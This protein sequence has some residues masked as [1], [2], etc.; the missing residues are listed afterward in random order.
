MPTDLRS[1][2]GYDGY[3][4]SAEGSMVGPAGPMRPMLAEKGH[5][6]VLTSRPGVPRKLFVHRA[7]LLAFVGPPPPGKPWAL[8]RDDI[9][10]N[11]SL[12]NLYWGSRQDN[13]DD[14]VRNGNA[15]RG[16]GSVCSKLTNDQVIEIRRRRPAESLRSLAAEFGVSHTAI[17]RAALGKNWSHI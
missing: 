14:R 11:N 7:V 8:H 5:A 12:G 4:V 3:S 15:P 10:S 17:R 6:Y 1:V 13:A 2:P 16:E 9:P